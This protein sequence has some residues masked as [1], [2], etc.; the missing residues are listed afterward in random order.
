MSCL[1][2]VITPCYNQGHFL[3]EAIQSIPYDKVNYGI[4]HIII[5][6]GST[7]RFT[8]NKFK[9]L[10]E[11]GIHVIHQEN[12]G[13][14]ATR[15]IGV[16]AA[17]GKYIIPL[18]ADNKLTE[19]YFTKA[20]A[21]LENDSSI[22]VVYSDYHVFGDEQKINKTG[23]FDIYRMCFSNKIDACAV[24]C[25]STFEKAGGYDLNMT[26]GCEDWDLWLNFYF[27]GA[28]FHYISE[29]GFYYR[30]TNSSMLRN[31]TQPNI[32]AIKA[33]IFKKYSVQIINVLMERASEAEKM[34]KELSK[35]RK[36][37][38]NNIRTAVKLLLG[39]RII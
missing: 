17:K 39:R 33:Y 27:N 28:K 2:S 38:K 23:S 15:N 10:E 24:F 6:D 7:D 22:N 36:A 11:R 32:S 35:F 9:E 37:E 8:I 21:L 29:P 13:L 25:K 30:V 18:D 31:I 26:L 4:E 5:N 1:V 12:K 20:I 34:Q 19:L 14:A 3:E 16:A